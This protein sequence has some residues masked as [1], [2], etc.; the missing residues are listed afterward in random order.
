[1][2][3]DSL[4]VFYWKK[5]RNDLLSQ[6]LDDNG[7]S[8]IESLPSRLQA[9]SKLLF[10]YILILQEHDHHELD[11]G[12]INC[13]NESNYKNLILECRHSLRYMLTLIS[14]EEKYRSEIQK[15]AVVESNFHIILCKFLSQ[16]SADAKCQNLA[17]KILCNLGTGNP[18]TSL[19]ILNNIN[20]SPSKRNECLQCEEHEEITL[21]TTM[22]PSWS[23]IIHTTAST[24]TCGKRETLGAIVATIHNCILAIK[25]SDNANFRLESLATDKIIMCNLVRYI[26]P[27]ETIQ[28]VDQN[29]LSGTD[30]DLSDDGTHWISLLLEV[31]CTYGMFKHIYEAIGGSSSTSDGSTNDGITPEQ[32]V[33]LNCLS[34]SVETCADEG[35][36]KTTNMNRNPLGGSC[37]NGFN[38]IVREMAQIWLNLQQSK[39]MK[40]RVERYDGETSCMVEAMKIILDILGTALSSNYS[41]ISDEQMLKIRI[42]VSQDIPLLK[43]SLLELGMIIDKLGIENRGLKAREL[44]VSKDD[45]H[46]LI[47]LV[48]FL[49][50]VCYKCFLNQN[51]VRETKVPFE[52]ISIGRSSETD[53]NERN[54]LHVMLSCTS[55]AYGCFTLREWGIVA[56]RN[57]LDN[58]D[59]NQEEVAKLEA[60]QVINTPELENLGVKLNLDEKGKI[61][62]ATSASGNQLM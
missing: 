38:S 58:N 15:V 1:M 21:Q 39:R 24:T 9:L 25:S 53:S 33:L 30:R 12:T 14:R 48:R 3:I 37:P 26:L 8:P 35:E 11:S 54:G 6:T 19:T 10:Q 40:E 22:P 4:G 17:S 59:A 16:N 32:V 56:I 7:S 20:P 18:T 57:M 51:L 62:V 2:S 46:L 52:H 49:G 61:H 55:F 34:N 5:L 50:N 13:L 44:V 27:K 29:N 23:E 28:P 42:S 45:Q 60:Q 43:N 41:D 47:G 31:F 36:S